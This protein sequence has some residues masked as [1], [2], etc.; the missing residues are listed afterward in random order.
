MLP[1]VRAFRPCRAWLALPALLAT[2][3]LPAAGARLS[4]APRQLD[5]AW[6]AVG[7]WA[8]PGAVNAPG[9]LVDP[10]GVAATRDGVVFVADAAEGRVHVL[11]PAEPDRPWRGAWGTAGGGPGQLSRPRGIALLGADV[12][13]ADS[14]NHRVQRL[15]QDGRAIAS[16]PVGGTPW[17]IA[18]TADGRVLVTDVERH[19]VLELDATGRETSRWGRPGSG[20]GELD[21]PLGV[22]ELADGRVAVA[23]AGNL[24][25]QLFSADGTPTG[26]LIAV[27]S[28]PQALAAE[29][30]GTLLVL[31]G[32]AVRRYDLASG[33]PVA[34]SGF[35]PARPGGGLAVGGPD[36][37]GSEGDTV[38]L[39]LRYDFDF[40]NGL[41]RL[42]AP[43]LATT[44]EWLDFAKG[45]GE[46]VGPL[47]LAAGA[48]GDEAAFHVLDAWP[49]I[50]RFAADGAY[51]DG[52]RQIGVRDLAPAFGGA[53]AS[54]GTQLA[55]LPSDAQQ[56]AWQLAAD[57]R[58]DGA[59][60]WIGGMTYD[61][62]RERLYA[63]ELRAQRMIVLDRA[64]AL[65][66]SWPLGGSAFAAISD[67]AVRPDGR[68]LAVNRTARDI[69]V[70]EPTDGQIAD[71]WAVIGSPLRVASDP[72][73]DNAGGA[74]VLT[75]EGD[76]WR[77]AADGTLRAWWDAG[78]LPGGRRALPSDLV[79]TADGRVHATDGVGNRVMVYARD[80]DGLPAIAP[81]G[82][83][84]RLLRDKQAGPP[85][86]VLGE[87][88]AVTLTVTG[89][90]RDTAGQADI[91]LVLDRSGSM[92]GQKMAAARAAVAA[93]LVDLD[94]TRSRA[95]LVVFNSAATL[96]S[97]LTSDVGATLDALVGFGDA[98]G[99]T[100]IGEGLD[101]A[102]AE[103]AASGRPAAAPVVIV[104]TDGRP[105]SADVDADDA[106]DRAKAAGVR[107]ITIGFGN[108]T[109][110]QLLE[111][112]ASTPSDFFTAPGEAQLAAI[113][114]EI[115]RRI[116]GGVLLQSATITDV[117]PVDMAFVPGSAVPPATQQGQ[118]LTWSMADARPPIALSYRV[119]PLITGL[120]PTNVEARIR[121]RDGL[122]EPGELLFPIP[123]VL[124]LGP[125]RPIYLP[126]ALRG[127]CVR[128]ARPV[129]IVLVI[130]ISSSMTPP[131][132]A[133]AKAAGKAFVDALT[134]VRDRAAIVAFDA[135]ARLVEGL[136]GNPT[137]LHNALDGLS[138]A[139]G[140]AI[141]AG[142]RAALDELSS[143]RARA[144]AAHVVVLMTDG[145]NNAGPG[146][147][148]ALAAEARDAHGVRLY[149]VALGE[150][151]DLVLMRE[152]AGDPRRAFVSPRPEDLLRVFEDIA[153]LIP[154]G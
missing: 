50:Q 6:T 90:C 145:Q 66:G 46:L 21:D 25:V 143:P 153:G 115:A 85:R 112:M 37:P 73:A 59:P 117:L 39:S 26:E 91:V 33:G 19:Q 138:S 9:A 58:V 41:R 103:L 7:E 139:T 43:S 45:P 15:A 130:D 95:G 68:L 141:D 79:A 10:S 32:T 75:D 147:V 116:S 57:G 42:H 92:A 74:Y 53:F 16:W 44:G 23:D 52:E 124:V 3:A 133:A 96:A 97:P 22:A 60:G 67:L 102:V 154:C 64:G 84:C 86:V 48:P 20:I 77:Y 71:R 72:A 89:T 61:A 127:A 65:Q 126:I 70:R 30:E 24:R 135:N 104:L 5:E 149:T 131:K 18:V 87:T 144:G 113:Y 1:P 27:G 132:L 146:P 125:P 99:G 94:P 54:F 76:I 4:A 134:P 51:L 28:T 62:A 36:L 122:G 55:F 152:I 120:R 35:F 111:R 88:V 136:T 2:M 109:D 98:V 150:D 107:V 69:E 119:R 17:G 82:E 29:A 142:M 148:R 108:D 128:D 93:F 13:V 47:R 118:L 14:G 137:R 81:S 63:V 101:V 105:D 106:A 110:P 12:L 100:D 121:Y 151:A 56:P 123:R 40:L 31:D 114:A 11:R 34:A 140:T 80:P 8:V 129:D 83:G 38:W 78:A 49:R